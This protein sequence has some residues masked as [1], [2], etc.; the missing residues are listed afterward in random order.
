MFEG[1]AQSA[2]VHRQC[3]GSIAS[4][5]ELKHKTSTAVRGVGSFTGE[6]L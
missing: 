1:S 5:P 2:L 3:T 4:A 6:I